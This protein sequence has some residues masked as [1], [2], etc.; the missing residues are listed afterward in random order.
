MNH[1]DL[2]PSNILLFNR[3]LEIA[4]ITDFGISKSTEINQNGSS[5]KYLTPN[6]ASPEILKM[7][8]KSQIAK[9]DEEKADVYSFGITFCQCLFLKKYEELR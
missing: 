6:Y 1:R 9:V 3:L 7:L 8:E 4:K 5:I 2:K